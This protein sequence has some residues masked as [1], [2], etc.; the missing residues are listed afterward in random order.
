MIPAV[1]AISEPTLIWLAPPKMM[2]FWLM[3]STCPGALMR[4]RIWLGPV[5]PTTRLSAVQLA[6]CWLK[7]T[8]VWLPTLKLCQFRIACGAV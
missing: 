4:P 3:T 1:D 6:A 8:V 7:L 2:P 5:L